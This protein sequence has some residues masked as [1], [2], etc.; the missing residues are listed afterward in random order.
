[1][2]MI[3]AGAV[4]ALMSLPAAAEPKTVKA[5]FISGTYATAE[6]CKKL[7]AI[8][9]G[10]PKNVGTVPETL[11]AEGFDGWEGGC[12][13]TS[14]KETEKGKAWVAQMA[15][16]EG[17]EENTETDTFELRPDGTIKVTNEGKATIFERCKTKEAK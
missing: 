9:K 8:A 7:D 10:G 3:L 11:T 17:A 5:G 6:G 4:M 16:A 2:R 13:F 12:S 15:C 14:I 1:M